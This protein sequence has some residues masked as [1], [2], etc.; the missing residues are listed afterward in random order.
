MSFEDAPQVLAMQAALLDGSSRPEIARMLGVPAPA[1]DFLVPTVA[2][3]KAKRGEWVTPERED[4]LRSAWP[5]DV[6]LAEIM[7]KL[8]SMQGAP[9][10][11]G[12]SIGNFC[13]KT[14]RVKRT[15]AHVLWATEE[16]K[17]YLR[18]A[19]PADVPMAEV[20][21]AMSAM[22][23]REMPCPARIHDYCSKGLKVHRSSRQALAVKAGLVLRAQRDIKRRKPKVIDEL[24]PPAPERPIE[25]RG[26]PG[27]A[28]P[29]ISRSWAEI[30]VIGREWG[31]EM[32]SK[33]DLISL[34]KSRI[35]M[36]YAPLA[37]KTNIKWRPP[38][39]G[40]WG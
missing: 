32:L 4:Y 30:V 14:L 2:G 8:S 21:A 3:A 29:P 12:G 11:G 36:G 37:I 39:Y 34:N 27:V 31:R 35:A 18:K 13:T 28:L 26:T 40:Q 10:P 38:A 9:I 33:W 24:L 6:P 25:V 20:M 15:T 5:D 19:W 16:R 1:T 17:D 23:G 7:Q 22:E